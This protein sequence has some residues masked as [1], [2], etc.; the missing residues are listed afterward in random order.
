MNYGIAVIG[1]GKVGGLIPYYLEQLGFTQLTLFDSNV[2]RINESISLLS[3]NCI[4]ETKFRDGRYD[5]IILSIPYFAMKDFIQK[6][7]GLL[8]KDKKIIIT[9]TRVDYNNFE[10]YN[11]FNDFLIS[12]KITLIAGCGL[13]PGLTEIVS[14]H[15]LH[16]Y[17]DC[18][19]LRIYCG[20]IPIYAKPP[21]YYALSFGDKLPVQKR[22]AYYK[23]DGNIVSSQRFEQLEDIFIDN[24]GCLEAFNDGMLPFYARGNVVRN[25]TQKTIRWPGFVNAIS[26]LEQC[27][28]FS[29]E[30][31]D[32]YGVT[33]HDF[34]H[35]LMGEGNLINDSRD[36]VILHILLLDAQN[37]TLDK[38]FILSKFDEEN[39][40]TAMAKTTAF[41]AAFA[42]KLYFEKAEESYIKFGVTWAFEYFNIN[43]TDLLLNSMQSYKVII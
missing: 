26:V 36:I 25:F 6:Y 40:I 8:F 30:P 18:N 7:H 33:P 29:T 23:V 28:M 4:V 1:L 9:V 19:E 10:D 20:G 35:R 21:F 17:R 11:K 31:L 5:L 39:N 22:K 16:K 41:P 34:I 3:N 15:L 14:N 2:N 42:A 43:D 24:I 38:C 27:G 13:E 32:P 37:K 12:N